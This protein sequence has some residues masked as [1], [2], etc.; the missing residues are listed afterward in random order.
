MPAQD[1]GV[2]YWE[3]WMSSDPKEC[4][5]QPSVLLLSQPWL[6][7]A[8]CWQQHLDTQ[9]AGNYYVMHHSLKLRHC[10]PRAVFGQKPV[11]P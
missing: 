10:F 5:L 7:S 2:A 1:G 8:V 9:P 11:S 6:L 4:Y 3:F